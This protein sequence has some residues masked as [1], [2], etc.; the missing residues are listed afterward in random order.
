MGSA[1]HVVH[2]SPS[3]VR[4]GDTLFFMVGWDQYGFDKKIAGTHYAKIVF[5]LPVGSAGHV[6]HSRPS[7]GQNGD[8]LF[9]MLGWDQYGFDKKSWYTLRRTCVFASGGICGSRSAFQCIWGGDALFFKLRWD[10]YGYDK[11]RARTRYAELVFL[12]PME[13]VG[14]VVYSDASGL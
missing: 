12:H 10:R 5:L 14:H 1:G 13:S 6:V 11:K 3:V 9:F 2:A 4:N 8:T 7:G